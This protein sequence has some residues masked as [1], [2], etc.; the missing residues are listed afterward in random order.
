[1]NKLYRIE[2]K[3]AVMTDGKWETINSVGEVNMDWALGFVE[4]AKF[5]PFMDDIELRI[6]DIETG[7][8]V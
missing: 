6:I 5:I 4:G 8:E 7:K 1:M 3:Q 2:F